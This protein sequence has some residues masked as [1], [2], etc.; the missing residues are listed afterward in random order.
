MEVFIGLIS[1]YYNML[2][3]V[4]LKVSNPKTSYGHFYDLHPVLH[5]VM[6][7]LQCDVNIKGTYYI[8]LP[9]YKG[10]T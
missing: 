3:L 10:E 5:V 2:D 6:V 8:P 1:C 9:V 7:V 4:T